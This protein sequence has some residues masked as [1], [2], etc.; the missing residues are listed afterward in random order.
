MRSRPRHISFSEAETQKLPLG[1]GASSSYSP[2]IPGDLIRDMID[3]SQTKPVPTRY[4]PPAIG[5]HWLIAV[6]IFSGYSLGLFMVALPVSAE[7]LRYFSFHKWIGVS[8][9][10]LA[11]LRVLWRA[12]HQP[13]ALPEGARWEHAAAHF[14][15]WALYGLML[16]IPLSGWL[17]SSAAGYT[18]VY[19]GVLPLPDLLQKNLPLSE[20]LG[21]VHGWLNYALIAL[22]LG[23]AG[24][25]ILHHVAR[26]DGV[27]AR[28]L[29]LSGAKTWANL[30]MLLAIA[31]FSLIA[32]LF[33]SGES[34]D[35]AS[36]PQQDAAQ[37]Q[38]VASASGEI[39]AEFR[40]MNVP[41]TGTFTRFK[42]ETLSFDADAPEAA[43]AIIVVDAASFD[44]GDA[45]YNAEVRK[46]EW[47]DTAKFPEARFESSAVRKLD[48]T[49][50]EATGELTVKGKAL[51]VTVPFTVA[52]DGGAT[53]YTGEAKVSR[54]AY[55]IGDDSWNDVLDD[56]VIVR[57]R[58]SV[59]QP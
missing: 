27:L 5:L 37:T 58:I 9:F 47:F 16:A 20:Q 1:C 45:D 6:L 2:S 28:M 53:V 40:Q 51:P 19:F 3:A 18:T 56:A 42:P 43:R 10:L 55:G 54:A 59:A 35:A 12:T 26:R 23:H 8:V 7:K 39:T 22:L 50:F 38:A 14:T 57:F 32:V 25:A 41:V 11:L 4:S 29:P 46:A 52:Q 21:A 49:H 48:A 34:R 31:A 30:A 13:P 17:H 33:V 44:I 24:A 15:H 36:R